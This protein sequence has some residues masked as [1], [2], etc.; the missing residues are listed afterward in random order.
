MFV[1]V[2]IFLFWGLNDRPVYFRSLLT[3][4]GHARLLL[5]RNYNDKQNMP[6]I[7]KCCDDYLKCLVYADDLAICSN[8]LCAIQQSIDR[9]YKYCSDNYLG[10][11]I[12]KTKIM[13]FRR[14]GHLAKS[15]VTTC[16]SNP[17]EF[18]SKFTY[19]SV[20]FQTK[21]TLTGHFDHLMNKGIA[22]CG[23]VAAR[24]PLSKMSPAILAV[25]FSLLFSLQPHMDSVQYTH[26]KHFIF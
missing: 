13:K 8:N 7:V 15:D 25:Y 6:A 26:M 24:M 17:I 12:G 21:G 1:L 16:N 2:S 5:L 10:I 18:V 20:V 14:G 9:L 19:L 4:A 22:A 3:A 23:K 11:N